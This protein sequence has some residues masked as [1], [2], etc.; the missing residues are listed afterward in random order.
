MKNVVLQ[1]EH[2]FSVVVQE[3]QEG[4]PMADPVPAPK[5]KEN[6]LRSW[7]VLP[8]DLLKKLTL[9]SSQLHNWELS[10]QG[11]WTS[12]S[13]LLYGPPGNG[14]TMIVDMLV[15]ESGFDLVDCTDRPYFDWKQKF[16][17]Q[18]PIKMKDLFEDARAKRPCLL[19][20]GDFDTIFTGGDLRSQDLVRELLVAMDEMKPDDGVFLLA[21]ANDA[22]RIAEPVLARFSE[23]ILIPLPDED[24]RRRILRDMIAKQ[25]RDMDLA[26]AEIAAQMTSASSRDLRML[27]G[28][29]F[30]YAVD[31]ALDGEGQPA[32]RY[33]DL[34]RA[35]KPES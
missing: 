1:R 5:R 10:A 12:S 14:K 16:V 8:E 7:P 26:S 33:E 6:S 27:V 24:R 2:L 4:G 35:M 22:S 17:G 25:P 13:L 34:L 19:F 28:H 20:W 32:L 11:G 21:E 23:R 31:R 9:I 15:Q 29:A 3:A 18:T 30:E